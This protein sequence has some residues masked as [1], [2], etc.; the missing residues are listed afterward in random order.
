MSKDP[1]F[2]FYDGDAAKDVS[3]M[4][5]LERGCYFDIIQAQRKFGRLSE[6]IIK[7]IL[8]NDFDT[9]WES[10]KICL[11]YDND[12][13]FIEWLENSTI[14]RKAYSDSRRDNRTKSKNV[15]TIELDKKTREN[16][17]KSYDSHMENEN[18][19]SF[20]SF[21]KDFNFLKNSK[22]SIKDKKAERQF[23]QRLKDGYTKSDFSL[24]IKNCL[25]DKYHIE[26]PK[27]LTPEF[28]TRSDKLEKYLNS[29]N[30]NES[31]I[32]NLSGHSNLPQEYGFKKDWVDPRIRQ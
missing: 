28:I 18:E 4:N 20:S 6:S 9:C 10:V 21:I 7:K 19:Y 24:A 3:H 13:Y 29:E 30:R 25:L 16:I 27:F 17:C 15:D 12:M 26:N 1:A 23:Y 2:L 11:S 22:F 31:I 8:G 5:R 14:K 32:N